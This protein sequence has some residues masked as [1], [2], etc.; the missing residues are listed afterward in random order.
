MLEV[1]PST[2]KRPGKLAWG[3]DSV[4]ISINNFHY[5]SASEVLIYGCDFCFYRFARQTV[6]DKVNIAVIVTYTSSAVY[7]FLQVKQHFIVYVEWFFQGVIVVFR[8]F[9]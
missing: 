4:G 3:S 6:V 7:N 2:A 5:F 9:P 8:Q 1:A